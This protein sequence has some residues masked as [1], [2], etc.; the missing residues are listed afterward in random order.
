[1][2]MPDLDRERSEKL[3]SLPEFLKSYNEGLPLQFPRASAVLL[4]EF[5]REHAALFKQTSSWSL[6]QHRKVVMNWL[7]SHIKV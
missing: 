7:P 4:R 2:R 5:K 6:N 1:M 3:L